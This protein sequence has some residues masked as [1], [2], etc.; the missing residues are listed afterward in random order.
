MKKLFFIISLMPFFTFCISGHEKAIENAVNEQLTRYPKST[1]Q[2]I[3]KNFYQ[4]R[5]GAE[6]AAPSRENAQ[7]YLN[8]ELQ[9]MTEA[10]TTFF[11]EKIGWE[12]HF[13]RVPLALVKNEKLSADTLLNAFLESAKTNFPKNIEK[14]WVKEWSEI[15]RIIKGKKYYIANF[16]TDR[17]II[18]SLLR[19][20]PTM[21]LHHSAEFNAAYQ[22][23]YRIVKK[24]IF[25]R[26]AK[27]LE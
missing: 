23:H 25:E 13:V 21:A 27:N 11:V 9:R 24:E 12:H 2:D 26:I 1:L 19:E 18:D 16:E 14:E 7:N 10:D 5:F 15:V 4:D 3:Y 6:H 22:P 20:Q 8:Y 17:I